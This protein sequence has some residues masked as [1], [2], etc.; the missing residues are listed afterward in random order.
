MQ[1]NS[2]WTILR[3][4]VYNHGSIPD[5]TVLDIYDEQFI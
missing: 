1:L 4:A 5:P 2:E 3:V